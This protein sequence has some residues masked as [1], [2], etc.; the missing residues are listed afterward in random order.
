M[1][2]FSSIFAQT[3][4]RLEILFLGDNGHH[5]PIERVPTIMAALG[6]KG[7][8]FTYT[9]K[10]EDINAQNLS[11][12]DAL[13]IFAN[14]DEITPAAEKALLDYVASGKGLLPIH[15]ASYCFRNSPEYVKMVGGQFW[16]HRMDTIQVTNVQQNH[17]ILKNLGTIRTYDETY[18]HSQL[19]ADNNVLQTREIKADQAKISLIL[20]P[21]LIL[22]HAHTEKDV[23][24]IQ[25]TAMM[26]ALGTTLIS[27][28]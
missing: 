3:G 17:I 26:N 12:Y 22:G 23:Y 4:R 9:D 2:S 8:N 16:R 13:M 28:N 20:K 27:R 11:K 19:Q 24:F 7:I 25:L 21:S 1:L 15:C 18:L 6:N 5:K 10:L 14:W